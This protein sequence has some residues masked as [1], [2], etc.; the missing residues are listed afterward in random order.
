MKGVISDILKE[1]EE[2]VLSRKEDIDLDNFK[3]INAQD[4]GKSIAFVDGGNAELLKA[5]NF[6]LQF[7]RICCI[8]FKNNKKLNIVKNEFFVLISAFEDEG[9]KYKAKIFPFRGDFPDEK[10]LKFNI[11]DETVMQGKEKANISIVGNIAR[12]FAELKL[13]SEIDADIAV[14]D[15][16]LKPVYTNE[17]KYIKR[18]NNNACAIAKTSDII[19]N[20]GNC[21]VAQLNSVGIDYSWYYETKERIYIK[22]NKA[23]GYVFSLQINNKDNIGKIINQIAYNSNDAV[24]PGYPYGLILADKFA[25]ISNN[26]KQNLVLLFRTIADWDKIKHYVNTTNAHDIL[27]SVN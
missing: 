13:A 8:I 9:I 21:P 24:F 1:L 19:T 6:S 18:L 20:K 16:N 4:Y 17:D 14:I 10:D 7:I 15:G 25:R 26:E 27:D 23:S 2:G 3:R 5:P 11:L 22:L 12:R